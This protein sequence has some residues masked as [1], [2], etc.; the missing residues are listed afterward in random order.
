MQKYCVLIQLYQYIEYGSRDISVGI[1]MGYGLDGPG[2]IPGR[3]TLF[4]SNS[5]GPRLALGATQRPI[6]WVPGAPSPG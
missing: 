1:A 6:Q 4:F 5:Q 2:S 3:G